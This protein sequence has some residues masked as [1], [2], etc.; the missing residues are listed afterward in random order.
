MFGGAEEKNDN[1]KYDYEANNSEQGSIN[2]KSSNDSENEVVGLNVSTTVLL[3]WRI[4][5]FV[6]VF[7]IWAI[8]FYQFGVSNFESTIK[9]LTYWAI[10]FTFSYSLAAAIVQPEKTGKILDRK[11]GQNFGRRG[12]RNLGRRE[13]V[14][15]HYRNVGCRRCVEFCRDCRFGDGDHLERRNEGIDR[16]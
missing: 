15:R 16:P 2:N 3:V 13:F 9:Y 5:G 11:F 6:V 7:A 1:V 12:K 4:I 14:G 10:V 8:G